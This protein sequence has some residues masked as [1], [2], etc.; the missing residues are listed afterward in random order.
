V[1]RAIADRLASHAARGE[2]VLADPRVA[3]DH[4][5]YLVLGASLDR[6]L[7]ERAP[8]DSVALRRRARDGAD[9]FLRA[10]GA[11]SVAAGDERMPGA[12]GNSATMEG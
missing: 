12:G 2:L 5:V 4:F 11:G 6:A 10:Y 1:L 3:A 9:A 8:I 7:F